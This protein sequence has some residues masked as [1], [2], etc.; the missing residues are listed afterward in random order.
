MTRNE[1]K[2]E[3]QKRARLAKGLVNLLIDDIDCISMDAN[4]FD[5]YDI[6]DAIL[7]ARFTMQKLSDCLGGL[8]T[9]VVLSMENISRN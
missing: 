9:V 1:L 4:N 6:T 8:E 5:L 2:L 3:M 7:E